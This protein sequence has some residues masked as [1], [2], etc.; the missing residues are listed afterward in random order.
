MAESAKAAVDRRNFLKSAAAGAA[1]LVATSPEATQAQR[2]EETPRASVPG[3]ADVGKMKERI[4]LATRMLASEGIVGSSG[5]VS[6]RVPGTDRVLVGPS[7]V[8]RDVITPDDV[9]MVDLDSRQLAGNRKRPDETEIHTGIYRARADVMS[10]VHTHPT[11]SVVFSVTK[12][13][14]L[15]VH[16]HGAIFADGVPVFDSVGHINTRELGD[17]LARALGNRR[18]VLIKMHGAAIVGHSL[19]EAFVAA[20]QLEET[21]QQQLLA[22]QAGATV[23]PMTAA[24]VARCV[25]QSW[26]P[27]SIQKRWQYYVDKQSLKA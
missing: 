27:F 19:E 25:K 12:R 8:S 5:H 11:Y 22:E 9:V 24:D 16:M 18:A 2:S 20:F 7:D 21:A 14:I 15:P 6:M 1:V 26:S 17:G 10:V 3:D 13:P 4:A 23:E